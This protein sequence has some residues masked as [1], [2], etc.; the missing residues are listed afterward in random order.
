MIIRA[1]IAS[2]LCGLSLTPADAGVPQHKVPS[3]DGLTECSTDSPTLSNVTA[4]A[5][6]FG[7]P[8]GCFVSSEIV[9]ITAGN[10]AQFPRDYAYAIFLKGN[11]DY[12]FSYADFSTLESTVKQQ[13]AAYKPIDGLQREEYQEKIRSIV[14]ELS[15]GAIADTKLFAPTL[16]GIDSADE[17]HYIVTTIRRR[18]FRIGLNDVPTTKV[19]AAILVFKHG[20]IIRLSFARELRD[21]SDVQYV[22]NL[23]RMWAAAVETEASR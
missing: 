14:Q 9:K 8:A 6:A 7:S 4:A 20:A 13:W 19:E 5:Q 12:A 2:L 1:V 15:T 11:H 16:V 22:R 17:N 18:M 23:S 3:P 21:E 10:A